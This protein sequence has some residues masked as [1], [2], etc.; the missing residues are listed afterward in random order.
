MAGVGDHFVE[1]QVNA[2]VQKGKQEMVKIGHFAV[3]VRQYDDGRVA[4]RKQAETEE[5]AD[6]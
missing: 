5:I 4:E 6:E 1:V 3:I 2:E